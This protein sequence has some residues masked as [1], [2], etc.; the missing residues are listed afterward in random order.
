MHTITMKNVFS[1][2]VK[3]ELINRINQLSEKSVAQ[4]GSMEAGQMLA[5]CCVPYEMVYTSIHPKP[6]AFVRLMLKTFV[7]KTVVG[8]KP[9]PKNSKTAPQFLITEK[10]EIEKEKKRLIEFILK[11]QGLGESYFD[12]KVSPSFGKLSGKEWN[13]LFYKHVDHHLNQFGV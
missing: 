6:N 13:T 5:H 2:E 10:K 4:W 3:E 7:K 11:T 1:L 9:Y 12:G 8:D